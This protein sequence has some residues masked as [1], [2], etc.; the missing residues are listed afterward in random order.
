LVIVSLA[1]LH[2]NEKRGRSNEIH[3]QIFSITKIEASTNIFKKGNQTQIL[4]TM[5]NPHQTTLA[6]RQNAAETKSSDATTLPSSINNINVRY[7]L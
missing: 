7:Q 3:V 1:V 2:P 6:E 5:Y 4:H